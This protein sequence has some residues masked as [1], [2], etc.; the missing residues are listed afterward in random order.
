M[1]GTH[2][3]RSSHHVDIFWYLASEPLERSQNKLAACLVASD[4]Q[5]CSGARLTLR[6]SWFPQTRMYVN[7]GDAYWLD[8]L[9]V[10]TSRSPQPLGWDQALDRRLSC[11]L[12]AAVA[13]ASE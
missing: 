2:P 4:A 11:V 13:T 12:L 9:S 7:R 8:L 1:Q 6:T 5:R 3:A 10:R